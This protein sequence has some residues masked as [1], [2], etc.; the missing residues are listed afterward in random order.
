MHFRTFT[1][2]KSK[3]MCSQV[4]KPIFNFWVLLSQTYLLCWH[5]VK[6]LITCDHNDEKLKLR[7]KRAFASTWYLLKKRNRWITYLL[8][9][10]QLVPTLSSGPSGI[11]SVFLTQVSHFVLS[12]SAH[13]STVSGPQSNNWRRTRGFSRRSNVSRWNKHRE[14]SSLQM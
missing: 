9:S 2:L 8:I 4:D 12:V 7:W 11:L 5:F 14:L 10:M 6:H 1:F 3:E 13:T